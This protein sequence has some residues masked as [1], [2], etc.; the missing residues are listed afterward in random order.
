MRGEQN[1]LLF[2]VRIYGHTISQIQAF[3]MVSGGKKC[4]RIIF[5]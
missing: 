4:I 1:K 3:W 2:P 5:T